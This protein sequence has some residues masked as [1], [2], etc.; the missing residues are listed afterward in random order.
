MSIT[1][2][3][4]TLSPMIVEGLSFVGKIVTVEGMPGQFK[5]NSVE[6]DTWYACDKDGV[7]VIDLDMT[8]ASWMTFPLATIIP[9]GHRLG[10]GFAETIALSSLRR[11]VNLS[12]SWV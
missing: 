10:D 5:V 4:H 12:K 11:G 1:S 7:T 3:T 6:G 8:S 2:T 9:V